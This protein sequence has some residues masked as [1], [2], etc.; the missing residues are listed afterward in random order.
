M[1]C[2]E[3]EELTGRPVKQDFPYWEPCHNAI[4]SNGIY[5]FENIGGD[6]DAV[7]GRRVTFAAFPWRW[8]GGDGCID[9]ACKRTMPLLRNSKFQIPNFQFIIARFCRRSCVCG[10]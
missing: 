5:G 1:A 3:Y 7:T 8:V 6:L 9:S 2:R 10:R 4:L